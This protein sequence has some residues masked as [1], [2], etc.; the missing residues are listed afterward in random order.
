MMNMKNILLLFLAG[1]ASAIAANKPN[2]IY[3]MC[4]ELGYYELSCMGSKTIQTP[5]IDR[6]A[7]EGMTFSQALAGSSVCAPTR[8][9]L[10]TGKHS[11]HTSVRVN[12]GGT[13]LRAEEATIASVLKSRG[14][15]TGGFGKWGCGGRGSTG[16]PE[17]HGFDV[18]LGYYDQVHAHSYYPPYI[19]RNSEEVPLKGNKGGSIGET[20]S[21]YVIYE[22]AVK[23]IREN[24]EGPFLCYLPFTPPHGIFDIPDGDPAW[25]LYKDKDWPEQAR[26][27]AAMVSMVD[28]EVGELMALLKELQLD[29][30]TL[31]FF[32]GDNGG[33][34]YF[35]SKAFPR[36]FHGANV[37]P[38][39]G[40][41]FRGTKGT[42]YEG[43]LRIP[44]IVR[45]PGKIA[46]GSKSDLLWYFPDVMP[47][48]AEVAGAQTPGDTDGI[49]ILPTLL[50]A[51]AVGRRQ[52]LHEYLY[53]ELGQKIAVRM[54]DWKAVRPSP[55]SGW[56]L[57]DLKADISEA[58]NLAEK[59][60]G[61]L[62]T[63]TG[64]AAAAH[65][66]AVEGTF[67]DPAMH[68][69]DRQAKFGFKR[70]PAKGSA[71]APA[72]SFPTKGL[73]P[74]EK[75][76]LVRASSEARGARLAVHAFD[77]NPRT[78]WHS[79]FAP[80]LEKHP[81]TL[82]IDLGRSTEISGFRYMARQDTGWNGALARCSFYVGDKPDAFGEAIVQHTFTRKRAAQDV[83]FG[84]TRGRYVKIVVHSE[85]N[86]GPWASIAEFGVLLSH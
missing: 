73:Y 10:M 74:Q 32:C 56:E 9:V 26:R 44:M 51:Q 72:N 29:E 53:W 58:D 50:G 27:Y 54:G 52:D 25:A 36:G 57:Y 22:A 83:R 33:N 1:A 37:H 46:P 43:G 76:K 84:Q 14:Y 7:A 71:N 34:D 70:K 39:T 3:L 63:M 5:N 24:K 64:Y 8:A 15:A 16:V 40:A 42:L 6:L 18:F 41:E 30:N 13:P 20:Y 11:G 47:T 21:H 82:I 17:K 61:I 60:T 65:V 67:H 12:G 78:H 69:R 35:R 49:S 31:F 45:W 23:F 68:Q 59:E 38:K 81:H 75:M 66:D 79:Q 80:E 77:G 19:V 85:V 2:I 4:D 48:L 62:K 28:H 86:G 55:K